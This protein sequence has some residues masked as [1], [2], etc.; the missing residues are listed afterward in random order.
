MV[1]MTAGL[2]PGRSGF[3]GSPRHPGYE[4]RPPTNLD[5]LTALDY[6]SHLDGDGVDD[7]PNEQTLSIL[8]SLH[9]I[10]RYVRRERHASGHNDG[11]PPR[12]VTVTGE[13][14]YL[15]IHAEWCAHQPWGH[16]YV[17]VIRQLH[18][19][20]CRQAHDAPPAPLG[21]CLTEGCPGIVWPTPGGGRCSGEHQRTYDGLDLA[22]LRN[23]QQEAS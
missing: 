15:R 18:A 3:D 14:R 2:I 5:L 7:D 6:R 16:E 11:L 8:G 10:A 12:Q 19:Q 22:R 20:T 17:D 4:S 23:S 21:R 1:M 9:Q 13:A